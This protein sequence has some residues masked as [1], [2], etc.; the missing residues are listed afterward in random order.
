MFEDRTRSHA[1]HVGLGLDRMTTAAVGILKAVHCGQQPGQNRITKDVVAFAAQNFNQLVGE[2]Q[3]DLYEPP[4][5]QC[6]QWIEDAKLNQLRREGIRYAR[7]QL[8]D[9]DIYFL[10]RNIIHQFRTVTAVTSIAWHLRLKQYYPDQ[11]VVNQMVHGYEIQTPHYREKQTILPHPASEEKKHQ[12]P[13]KR[14]REGERTVATT[15]GG[16]TPAAKKPKPEEIDMRKNERPSAEKSHK[17]K[18]HK[19]KD[20]ERERD[21]DRSERSDKD[22]RPHHKPEPPSPYAGSSQCLNSIPFPSSGELPPPPSSSVQSQLLDPH[23]Q[24]NTTDLHP[25]LK[26]KFNVSNFE[27]CNSNSAT[28]ENLIPV[29]NEN[30]CDIIEE[31]VVVDETHVIMEH[32][33]EEEVVVPYPATVVS[34]DTD[35]D[36]TMHEVAVEVETTSDVIEDGTLH[37]ISPESDLY[38]TPVVDT[39]SST[40]SQHERTTEQYLKPQHD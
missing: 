40:P 7:I 1:D 22:R 34:I 3:L 36:E 2:L 25:S 39:N 28:G 4:I 27:H 16:S 38:T 6:V 21:R 23:H 35:D 30:V 9:N 14:Q 10:P 13:S 33:V 31:Q 26:F 37:L 8:Y 20:R 15:P 11:E 17:K 12:T 29:Q 5:S 24:A 19:D 18:K 32:V